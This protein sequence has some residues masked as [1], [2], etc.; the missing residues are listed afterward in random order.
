MDI[1]TI[2]KYDSHKMYQIY[3][4]WPQIA[5]KTFELELEPIDF[6]DIDHIVFAGMGGSGAIGDLFSAILS[7]SDIHVSLVKGY[8]LP[9]TVDKKTLVVVTSVSGNTIETLT[10]LDSA[11]NTDC[12]LIV[13]TSGGKIEEICKKDQIIFRK[14]PLYHSPRS[15]LINFTY[16]ILKV[17]NS[18]LPIDKKDIQESLEGLEL[19]QK[20]IG[21]HNL[22]DSN[23]AIKLASWITGIPIIY[24]PYGLQSAATRFKSS[25]QE[26]AKTHAIIEDI[27]E[28]CHNGIVSWEKPSV[29][30]PILLQGQDDF[31][32][33]KERWSI[34]KEFFNEKNV[35][36]KEIHSIKGGILSK[37][38]NLIYL[39]DYTSIYRSIISKTDPTP[40]KSIDFIKKRL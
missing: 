32:K 31:I 22:S 11:K 13:F 9:K 10:V 26:N 27:I 2:E 16:S 24:Y 29:V 3:D 4:K 37:L 12:K 23:P 38:I 8:L 36:F 25:L 17:L 15:S 40:I 18:L 14:I 21:S 39:L 30:Q 1:S 19:I 5:R 28:A 7:K 33:T 6:G 34:V 35:E 20:E